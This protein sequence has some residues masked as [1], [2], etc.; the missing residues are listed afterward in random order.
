MDPN[1]YASPQHPAGL[2][3]STN[4]PQR[5]R[6]PFHW[7]IMGIWLVTIGIMIFHAR[8]SWLQYSLRGF[9]DGAGLPAPVYWTMQIGFPIF[10]SAMA[11]FNIVRAWRGLPEHWTKPKKD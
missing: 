8:I 10:M 4:A 9:H 5:I 2:S 7:V 3:A 1:P 11:V 6:K